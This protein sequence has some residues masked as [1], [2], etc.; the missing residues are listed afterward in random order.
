MA[1]NAVVKWLLVLAL[2]FAPPAKAHQ[3]PGFIETPDQRTARY[4][5][6]EESAQHVEGEYDV[7]VLSWACGSSGCWAEP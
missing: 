3:F 6:R 7:A 5:V 1:M 2:Q 4:H